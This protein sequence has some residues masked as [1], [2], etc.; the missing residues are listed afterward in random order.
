MLLCATLGGTYVAVSKSHGL[1]LKM[2]TDFSEDTA[3]GDRWKSRLPGL[4]DF[5]A[6]LSAWYNT[7]YSTLVA[8]AVNKVSEYFMMYPDFTDTLTYYR[9]QCYVGMDEHD[10]DIGNTSGQGFNVVLAN[11]D[12]DIIYA[13]ATIV[14]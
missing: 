1:K 2:P 8:M 4:E 7:A 3:H 12:L 11:A 5:S 6:T 10:M 9:G 14:V 13:G